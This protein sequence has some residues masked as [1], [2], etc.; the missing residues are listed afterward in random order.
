MITGNL[1]AGVV[2]HQVGSFLPAVALLLATTGS[3]P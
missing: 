1:L 3:L 2:A